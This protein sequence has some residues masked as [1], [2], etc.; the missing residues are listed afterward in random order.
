ME[1]FA[2]RRFI[3]TPVHGRLNSYYPINAEYMVHE[4][5]ISM[6]A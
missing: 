1:S 3:W 2:S 4:G 5:G 6:D